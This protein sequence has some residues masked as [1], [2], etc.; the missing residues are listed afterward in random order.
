MARSLR[1]IP[2][3]NPGRR[4]PTRRDRDLWAPPRSPNV[5]L[6]P[7]AL[8]LERNRNRTFGPRRQIDVGVILIVVAALGLLGW[9]GTSFWKA[10][11]VDVDVAGIVDGAPLQPDAA[12]A[13]EIAI[14][15]PKSDDRFR[16]EVQLDGVEL[17]EH[18]EFDGDT[19]RVVP[20]HLI[21]DELVP[22]ALQEGEHELV[23]RVGRLFL[24]DSVFRWTYVVDSTPPA[25]TVPPTV[26]P[27]PI[28]AEV[29]VSGEVE[30]GAELLLD[31]EPVD[32]DDGRFAVTFDHPP[33]GALHFEAVDRAGNRTAAEAIVPVAYPDSTRAVHVS[34]AGWGDAAVR[35]SIL[36]LVDRHLIDAVQLDLKDERGVVGYDSE[37]ETAT[38]IGAVRASYDLEDAVA[39]LHDHG[40]RVIGRV[41]AFRDPIYASAAWAAGRTDEVLQTPAG[42]LFTTPDTYAN[43]VHPA[44]RTYNL[45]LAL[46]AVEHGVD[47]ILWDYVRRPEGNPSTMVVPGLAGPSSDAVATF[48]E[49]AHVALRDQGAYQ[50][51]TVL[52]ISVKAGDSVAQDVPRMARAVDYLSPSIFPA[53][54]GKGQYGVADPIR[55]PFEI[56]TRA[57]AD[58]QAVTAGAGARLLPW[59]Q[60]FTLKGVPYG[61]LEVRAQL[62]AAASLGIPGFLLWNPDARYTTD[63][64]TPIP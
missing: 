59:I 36:D 63:A 56:T 5:D 2:G 33:T 8:R 3:S 35:A 4:R 31:G 48:L 38:A 32:V 61:P 26:D 54:W 14:T 53:Y 60:D 46:E 28:D 57:L 41:V 19:L 9:M 37:L 23:L 16:A 6:T 22:G 39:T 18:L 64:L 10:T 50:G 34:A 25:L 21:A 20:E 12:R 62:D 58:F 30:D 24:S 51:A 15:V 47:D 42:E 40:A 1:D 45:D 11:R 44:V 55:E 13:L 27:V 52:G 43:Y 7:P 17:M 29:T 49:E